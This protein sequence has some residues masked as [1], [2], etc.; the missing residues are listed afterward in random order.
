M[1]SS[2]LWRIGAYG[3][4]PGGFFDGLIDDV[5]IYDHALSAGEIQDDMDEPVSIANGSAPTMP[6]EL[7]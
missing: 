6:G 3:G 1:G 7:L 2:D 5:R 4:S